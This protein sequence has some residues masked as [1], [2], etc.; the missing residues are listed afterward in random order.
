LDRSPAATV[1]YKKTSYTPDNLRSYGIVEEKITS[2]TPGDRGQEN[3]QP[4]G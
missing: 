1:D 3:N 4:R 2:Y